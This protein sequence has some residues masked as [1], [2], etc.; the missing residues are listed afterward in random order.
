MGSKLRAV[1]RGKRKR[2]LLPGTLCLSHAPFLA[3]KPV[4]LAGNTFA[5]VGYWAHLQ[6]RLM[7]VL[8][9]LDDSI[10]WC[11]LKVK[12]PVNCGSASIEVRSWSANSMCCSYSA[13]WFESLY[14]SRRYWSS[15]KKCPWS[16]WRSLLW[17]TFSFAS[18]PY[19]VLLLVCYFK[20]ELA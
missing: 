9:Q 8:I 11:D 1:D 15:T 13:V 16:M 12:L 10:F 4:F 2:I 20:W 6:R 14:V 3:C 5:F 19:R 7:F 18:T 17:Q